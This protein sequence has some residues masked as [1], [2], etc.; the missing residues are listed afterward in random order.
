VQVPK[1]G[2]DGWTTAL[3]PLLP[4]VPTRRD[5]LKFETYDPVRETRSLMHRS[6]KP[7][8][9]PDHRQARRQFEENERERD[10]RR[11]RAFSERNRLMQHARECRQPVLTDLVRRLRK[12]RRARNRD[13]ILEFSDLHPQAIQSPKAR[14]ADGAAQAQHRMIAVSFYDEKDLEL[15]DDID[16]ERNYPR[17][18][19]ENHPIRIH[20][21]GLSRRK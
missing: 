16:E 7:L 20:D 9:V 12:M 8:V 14:P 10:V 19:Q 6:R 4:P 13:G 5:A 2:E 3:P 15:F 17:G 21:F 11:K 18:V 1:N